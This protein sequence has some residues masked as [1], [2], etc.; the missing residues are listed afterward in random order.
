MTYSMRMLISLFT[1]LVL[2]TFALPGA[3]ATAQAATVGATSSARP[4]AAQ[5][6]KK[7]GRAGP[8]KAKKVDKIDKKPKKNDRGF[9]L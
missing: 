4:H 2:S 6:R 9:E 3:G 8:R 7:K 1:A 5:G